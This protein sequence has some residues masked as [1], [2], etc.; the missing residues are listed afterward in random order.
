MEEGADVPEKAFDRGIG[1]SCCVGVLGVDVSL[2]GMGS[3]GFT[4]VRTM[5]LSA[6]W[7]TSRRS[8]SVA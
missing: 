5:T 7:K 1:V 2:G 4:M 6:S 8:A 3:L